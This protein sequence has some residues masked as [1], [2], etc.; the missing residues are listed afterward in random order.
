MEHEALTCYNRL[1][2]FRKS[3]ANVVGFCRAARS[4][5]LLAIAHPAIETQSLESH[6]NM[7]SFV[8]ISNANMRIIAIMAG[9][10]P[11]TVHDLVRETKV[12][13]TAVTEQLRDLEAHGLVSRAVEQESRRGRPR[14]LYQATPVAMR[15]LFQNQ[16]CFL[17]P[18]MQQAIVDI[19]GDELLEDVTSR[20]TKMLVENYSSRVH[21]ETPPERL[22]ELAKIFE[23]EGVIIEIEEEEDSLVFRKRTCP[24]MPT[25][26]H[27]EHVC[28]IDES[29]VIDIV[30]APIQRI[31]DRKD[32]HPC[33]A[34]RLQ[35]NQDE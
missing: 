27:D 35:L 7:P 32:G 30:G 4:I 14:H 9:R 15:Q 13:R 26:D 18:Y 16:Y 23:E 6:Y 2:Y 11:M 25:Q 10:A 17:F 28:R 24:F 19:G 12:T 21:A 31:Q 22:R 1:Y 20:V 34:F 33:C 8:P 3:M 29:V 5:G